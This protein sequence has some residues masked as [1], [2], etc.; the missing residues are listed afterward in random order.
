MVTYA[1]S[2]TSPSF[3]SDFS[4]STRVRG[5][6]NRCKPE[7]GLSRLNF[8]TRGLPV[9]MKPT[10][11]K[12]S[13]SPASSMATI[14]G[15][16]ATAV[17]YMACRAT[18]SRGVFVSSN[19]SRCPKKYRPEFSKASNMRGP[20]ITMASRATP[21]AQAELRSWLL[22]IFPSS[23]CC[24]RLRG[25]AGMVFSPPVSSGIPT[26]YMLTPTRE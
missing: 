4:N 14:N 3:A 25:V 19:S 24:S 16:A 12:F 18:I 5:E 2:P 26:A 11:A 23:R 7:I 13:V 21:S 1:T 8:G 22:G 10:W 15:P 17:K 20:R 6:P 9:N